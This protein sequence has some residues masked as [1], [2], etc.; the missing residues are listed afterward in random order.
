MGPVKKSK[1][2]LSTRLQQLS[3]PRSAQELKEAPQLTE[4]EIQ[5]KED[6]ARMLLER[7]NRHKKFDFAAFINRDEE[8]E[9]KQAE[10]SDIQ[11][12]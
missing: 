5:K 1:H 9:A 2:G 6:K 12:K 8:Y 7:K 10:I 3:K 11:I 4:E